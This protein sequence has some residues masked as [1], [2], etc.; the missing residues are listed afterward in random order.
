M[1]HEVMTTTKTMTTATK[2]SV[3]FVIAIGV[4]SLVAGLVGCITWLVT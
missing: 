3:V 1:K 4:V 2:V